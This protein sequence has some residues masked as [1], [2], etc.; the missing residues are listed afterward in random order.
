LIQ[1]LHALKSVMK[2]AED[3]G[4]RRDFYC[5]KDVFFCEFANLDLAS[6][7]RFG[8]YE[9]TFGSRRLLAEVRDTD[10]SLR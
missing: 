5:G 9:V 3:W 2:H 7:T 10:Q 6:T 1:N 4:R 8:T